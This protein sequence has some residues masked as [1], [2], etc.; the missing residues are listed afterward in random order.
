MP[1]SR[2]PRPQGEGFGP[3][4]G[5]QAPGRAAL[6]RRRARRGSTPTTRRCSTSS[7]RSRAA[8]DRDGVDAQA[9]PEGAR[10]RRRRR[11]VGPQARPGRRRGRR[12]AGARELRPRAP[13]RAAA[14]GDHR[15]RSAPPSSPP[16]PRR[17]ARRSRAPL[18]LAY[19]ETRWRVPRWRI[20]PLLALP[21]GGDTDV[22]IGGRPAEQYLERLSAAVSR[23]PQDAHFQVAASGK[24]VIR[25]SAA[26][27]PARPA[28]DGQGA[29]PR[30]R[31][32][33][34]R[35]TANLVVR[36]ADPQRTT[37]AAKA[38]GITRRRLLVHDDLRRHAGPAQQRAA[39][40]EADRRH[41]DQA[42]RRRSRS[43][44]R[45]AS[46]RPRRASRRRP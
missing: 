16:P 19:G 7:A 10:D 42:G 20:A 3:V 39:R 41:A 17:L 27:T 40:R 4:R 1:R 6:R 44:A 30:R 32:R 29:S 23:A 34:D 43:T 8:I 24:I 33:A 45:R 46:G 5:L 9:R 13:G 12:R 36:V 35:R 37:E 18:R 31:S 38:M 14:A 21:S 25:P 22:S 26:G 28:R 2:R 15:P 11:P